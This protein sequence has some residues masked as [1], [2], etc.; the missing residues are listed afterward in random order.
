MLKVLFAD[1]WY[2]A[3]EKPSGMFV[4]R[5]D[6]DRSNREVLLPILQDQ[7]RQRLYIVH[8]L[9][10]PTSGLL[11]LARSSD[12]ASR[13]APLF[14]HRKISKRYVA[15]VRGFIPDSGLCD[16]PLVPEKG[17]GLPDSHPFAVPKPAVTHWI[18]QSRF[19][20][21]IS[22]SRFP[23]TRCSLV[24]VF[25][26]TGRFHQIRR[27][28]NYL[29]YPILGDTQHGDSRLNR[30][31]A[32]SEWNVDRMLLTAASL[33]FTHPFTHKQLTIACPLNPD[34]NDFLKRSTPSRVA[35]SIEQTD[36]NNQR[37]A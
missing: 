31:L 32:A 19:Q 1:D 6:A 5:S 10:R 33:S 8:R 26:K 4:H 22:N 21:P 12:A 27:H 2:I 23:T 14:E 13:L 34:F 28:F 25:P 7:L 20:L 18:V 15:I 9:D 24:N 30:A 16:T 29:G 3:V 11:L 37:S 17:R 36:S 35:A